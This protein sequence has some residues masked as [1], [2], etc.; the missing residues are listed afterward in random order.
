MGKLSD[1]KIRSLISKG[2]PVAGLAD[3]GVR[4]CG[5]RSAQRAMGE[6]RAIRQRIRLHSH[7]NPTRKRE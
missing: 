7:P 5:G 6:R 2:E 3:G 1:A 4:K